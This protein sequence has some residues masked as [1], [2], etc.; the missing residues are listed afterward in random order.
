MYRLRGRPAVHAAA[1][2]RKTGC[3][4]LYG[5]HVWPDVCRHGSCVLSESFFWGTVAGSDVRPG[6]PPGCK[7]IWRKHHEVFPYGQ[8]GL[9]AV[10]VPLVRPGVKG[11]GI[12]PAVQH[13]VAVVAVFDQPG[14][15]SLR[16]DGKL[17]QRT[18]NALPDV[19]ELRHVNTDHIIGEMR[20]DEV[21]LRQ[22][23][24]VGDTDQL[25]PDAAA[26]LK[27]RQ[28][29]AECLGG[30]IFQREHGQLGVRHP[31]QPGEGIGKPLG[32]IEKLFFRRGRVPVEL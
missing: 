28:Q 11:K 6:I 15:Q 1:A 7:F 20:P 24:I 27:F 22:Q 4:G 18:I 23:V 31:L 10:S 25:D 17:V 21:Q 30:R 5:R 2:R 29:L 16:G 8:P 3:N 19:S 13:R 12:D 9:P 26:V 32:R 14:G